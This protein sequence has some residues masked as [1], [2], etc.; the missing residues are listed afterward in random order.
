MPSNTLDF[1]VQKNSEILSNIFSYG[2]TDVPISSS[3]KFLLEHNQE[4]EK[5]LKILDEVFHEISHENLSFS[6]MND[7]FMEI[8]RRSRKLSDHLLFGTMKVMN[9]FFGAKSVVCLS[10]TTMVGEDFE[11][12]DLLRESWR[13]TIQES[14]KFMQE[15]ALFL[16][17]NQECGKWSG[18]EYHITLDSLNESSAM[19]QCC[20]SFQ[21]Y[22]PEDAMQR[23]THESISEM[24]DMHFV[25]NAPE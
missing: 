5:N 13:E 14:I 18:E 22:Y 21:V 11:Y 6:D 23:L 10:G 1:C 3:L 16:T 17:K 4:I 8:R 9:A 12:V 24:D 15:T 25:K 20:A 19:C 7:N 2:D